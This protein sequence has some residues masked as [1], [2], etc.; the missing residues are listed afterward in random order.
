MG[1]LTTVT[2]D[3]VQEHIKTFLAAPAEVVVERKPRVVITIIMECLLGAD[4]LTE[5][6]LI[7]LNNRIV[8]RLRFLNQMRV[9][10][11]MLDL[12]IGDRVTFNPKDGRRCL[13]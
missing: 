5:D 9:H 1:V 6:E 2:R 8:A 11:Q 12:R 7:D 4:K 13:G 3:R 10:L